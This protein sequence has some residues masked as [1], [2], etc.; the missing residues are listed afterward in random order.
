[1]SKNELIARAIHINGIVQGVGFRPFIFTLAH[2]HHITGWVRNS[3]AGV[4]I[5]ANGKPPDIQTFIMDIQDQAPPLAQIDQIDIREIESNGYLDFRILESEVNAG[6]F[7]PISPDISTC[8]DCLRELFDPTD[9]RYRYPFINCTNC[10]PRFSIIKDIPYD[11]HLT[12]MEAFQMCSDC[13]KEYENPFDRR[14]HAQP[15]ACPQC[16]PQ[17]WFESMDTTVAIKGEDALRSAREYLK[18][19][20]IVA[21]KGLGGFHLACDATNPQAIRT[22]RSRKQRSQ[23]SFAVMLNDAGIAE[24]H[25]LVSN[26][27][28][29][30]LTSK[31]KPIVILQ[32]R[33][34]CSL[35][36]E[37]APGVNTLGV[38]LPY[39]PL[40]ALLL[41]AEPGFPE[42]LIMTSGNISEE[43]IVFSNSSAKAELAHIA[44]GFLMHDREICMRVD[45]S[46]TAENEGKPYLFR[47]SRGYAPNPIL[48][49]QPLQEIL[50]V[51]AELKNTFCLTKGTYAFLSHHIGDLENQETIEAF[52]NCIPHYEHIFKVKP[53][54]IARD[55]HPDYLSSRY[56][57]TRAKAENLSLLMVQ[58]HHA[59]LAACLADNHW[60]E[61]QAV[62]G[63]IFDGTGLGSDG[64]IWGGEFLLGDYRGFE[65]LKYLEY[66]PLPGGDAAVRRP[67]RLAA[68]Y[69]YQAGIA[70][71]DSLPPIQALSEQER[72]VL[73]EQLNKRINCPLTSSMGRLFDAVASLTGVC[74]ENHYEAQAAIEF[75]NR[76]DQQESGHYTFT[77]N[78]ATISPQP[79]LQEIVSDINKRIPTRIISARFH[80]AIVEMIVKVSQEIRQ[81]SGCSTVALSG[82]V[83][84]NLYLLKKSVQAL[85][86]AGFRVLCHHQVPANDG[87]V[88]L[89]QAMIANRQLL[90]GK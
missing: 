21:V 28:K 17:I 74:Q 55:L 65:R 78:Q 90:F 42:V 11:R 61:D 46:V 82:G 88:A 4:D 70:W 39:T 22:L 85:N 29:M 63:I 84:Q 80:H 86:Q 76:L 77:I 34:D 45:D 64:N 38:M 66:Y 57:S 13:Q 59:H 8:P 36:L 67:K 69:L 32:R 75:E 72:Q 50:A 15:I 40:H 47:R 18:L 37:I 71:D 6:G 16:G 30:L 49:D 58:H 60:M 2:K 56:A 83:W 43:P 1:M 68:G 23:K 89:G 54:C 27:E 51:G 41:E 81:S 53:T 48:I 12:S 10:G 20:K 26:E 31:E 73:P 25:C 19:G 14:F 44:D 7:I 79:L 24:T 52:E 87:G 3:S 5:T 35:P 33:P 62:I 9:R